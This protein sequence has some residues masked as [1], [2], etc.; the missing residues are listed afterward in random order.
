MTSLIEDFLP[1]SDIARCTDF[2]EAGEVVAKVRSQS[3]RLQGRLCFFFFDIYIIGLFQIVLECYAD[4]YA[5][6][7]YHLP[8]RDQA[9][10]LDNHR[11]Q[12]QRLKCHN[13][14]LLSR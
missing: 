3:L 11:R 1:C 12:E 9:R 2:K 13:L 4:H 7:K 6:N 10:L 5:R 14:T 8:R